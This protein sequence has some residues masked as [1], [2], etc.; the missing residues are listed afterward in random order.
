MLAEVAVALV[1][2][3]NQGFLQGRPGEDIDAH[4][5]H[6]RPRVLGLL[7]ELGDALVLIRDDDTEAGSLFHGNRN[8]GNRHIR[9]VLLVEVQ[10]GLVVHL[11]DMVAGE[12]QNVVGIVAFYILEVLVNG[13]RR[14]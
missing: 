3:G 6:I 2:Q 13:V 11:V 12:N 8:R 9:L 5:S 4:R 1:F 14:A 10:H 7:L